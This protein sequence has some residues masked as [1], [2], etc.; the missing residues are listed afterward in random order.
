MLTKEEATA[1]IQFLD[2]V[3]FTGHQERQAMNIIISKLQKI[4][5]DTPAPPGAP[6]PPPNKKKKKK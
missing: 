6:V 5:Q 1:L 3:Q 2:R 4:A